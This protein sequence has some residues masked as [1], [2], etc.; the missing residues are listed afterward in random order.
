MGVVAIGAAVAV[1]IVLVIGG[2]SLHWRWTGLSDSVTLWDW[3]QVLALPVA[4]GVAPILMRHRQRLHY[5]HRR[6][7]VAAAFVFV[8]LAAAGY[9]VPMPWTGFTGN[10]LWDWLEL[11]LLPAVVAT[12]SLWASTWPPAR[13]H[14][15]AVVVAAGVLAV[16]AVCGYTVPWH[17][18]GF[19]GNTAWD[20]IKLLLLPIIVPVALLP[21]V[22]RYLTERLAPPQ[23]AARP[24]MVDEHDYAPA[25]H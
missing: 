1:L 4:L 21:P 9:L 13:T 10:T 16:L 8:A 12:A 22:T 6:A 17:W 25:G 23:P 20:W 5:R 11:L 7:L 24:G 2:Y 19:S 3:L 15:A 14:V 18:T